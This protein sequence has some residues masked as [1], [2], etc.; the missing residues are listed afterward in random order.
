MIKIQLRYAVTRDGHV[1]LYP[2]ARKS[3]GRFDLFI[4]Y[5]RATDH[6]EDATAYRARIKDRYG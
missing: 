2:S 4:P 1:M 6:D 3:N 5:T